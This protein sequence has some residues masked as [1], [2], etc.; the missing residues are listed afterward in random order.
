VREKAGGMLDR[1]KAP[2]VFVGA[3]VE[4]RPVKRN[5]NHLEIQV[6]GRDDVRLVESG[7]APRDDNQKG[8]K[9]RTVYYARHGRAEIVDKLDL[10]FVPTTPNGNRFLLLFNG[11]PLPKAEVTAYGPPKC[12]KRLATDDHGVFTLPTPWAGVYI[13]EVIHF[14]EKAGAH[15]DYKFDRT[16]HVSTL[17][18]V[19]K[20]GIRWT[21][22]R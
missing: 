2:R 22:R 16:R 20:D 12:G 5:E 15:G 18:F 6:K 19:Q 4:P 11:N 3:A 14:D 17:S 8:G 21:D 10:E 13:L 1:I 7:L 9:T